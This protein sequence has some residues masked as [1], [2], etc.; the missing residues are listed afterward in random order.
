MAHPESG[1][2][3]KGPYTVTR[4][5]GN[6]SFDIVYRVIPDGRKTPHMERLTSG[7]AVRFGG[8]FG[9]PVEEGIAPE[10]ERVVGIATGAGLGPL[11]G[12]AEAA[13]AAADGPAHIELYCGFRDLADVC[14]DAC[15]A[16]A[17]R[18]PERFTW[19]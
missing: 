8:R 18:Y 9:T 6:D 4:P 16:L 1:D 5:V 12:Y 3:L 14:G 11:V 17:M 2:G 7:D 13:L 10:V 15:D 19:R